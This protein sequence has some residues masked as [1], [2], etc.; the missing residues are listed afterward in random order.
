[1]LQGVTNRWSPDDAHVLDALR[2]ADVRALDLLYDSS[3]YVFLASLVHAEYGEAFGVYKPAAGEA[4]LS[5]FPY[6]SLHRREVAAY[7]LSCLLGWQM[8]PPM[9]E[10]SPPS[11][12]GT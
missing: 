11:L 5:D 10:R 3:N 9:A 6:G 2:E 12:R 4:P 1:M 7:E 8:V